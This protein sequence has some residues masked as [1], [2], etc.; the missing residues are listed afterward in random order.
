M[1][2]IRSYYVL[3]SNYVYEKDGASHKKV[4]KYD[5]ALPEN[6]VFSWEEIGRFRKGQYILMHSVIYR[7]ELL[8]ECGLQLP[9]HTFYV[10]NLYV[11]IPLPYTE[12]LYYLNADFYP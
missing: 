5:N 7:L 2:A 6:T 11:Y 10:D 1:Y 9:K 12:K 4:M 3:I 8:K